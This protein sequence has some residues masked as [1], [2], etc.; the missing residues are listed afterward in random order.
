MSDTLPDQIRVLHV[1][2][3]PDLA[4]LTATFLERENERFTVETAT[5]VDEG[6]ELVE[7]PR[8]DCVVSDYSIPETDGL[9]FLQVLREEY[10]ELPFILYTAKTREAIAD[11]ELSA[12]GYLQKRASPEQYERLADQIRNMVRSQFEHGGPTDT[13]GSD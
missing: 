10:P 11:E 1:D 9:E 8:P 6:L 3:E 12:T 2:D 13:R 5:S 7:E 4:D